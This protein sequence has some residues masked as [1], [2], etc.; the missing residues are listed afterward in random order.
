MKK[1]K[2]NLQSALK[3]KSIIEEHEKKLLGKAVKELSEAQEELTML[4]DKIVSAYDDIEAGTK[5]CSIDFVKACGDF[6]T[7]TRKRKEEQKY[8]INHRE[9]KVSEQRER[10]VNAVRNRKVF[11]KLKE[12]RYEEFR[13]AERAAEIKIFDDLT[14][15]RFHGKK[16]S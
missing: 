7:D 11:E 8:L 13:K 16:K 15:V 10:L 2:F 1:F 9:R 4:N 6:I 14:S 5:S 3:F 12:K